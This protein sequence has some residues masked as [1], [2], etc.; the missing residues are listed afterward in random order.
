MA[1]VT[2]LLDWSGGHFVLFVVADAC[3]CSTP[4]F[5]SCLCQSDD[6]VLDSGLPTGEVAVENRDN[7]LIFWVDIARI[8]MPTITMESARV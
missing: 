3:C 5:C 4:V 7:I 6:D 8:H 1:G 2:R